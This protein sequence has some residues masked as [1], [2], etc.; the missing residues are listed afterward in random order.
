MQEDLIFR[1]SVDS[2][3]ALEFFTKKGKSADNDMSHVP[4]LTKTINQKSSIIGSIKRYAGLLLL[5]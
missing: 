1:M 4:I 5:I 2:T 3:F